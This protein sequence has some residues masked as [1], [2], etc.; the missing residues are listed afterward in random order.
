MKSYFHLA[1]AAVC[2]L[3]LAGGTVQHRICRT[4]IKIGDDAAVGYVAPLL[5]GWGND[6][7][8]ACIIQQIYMMFSV[9]MSASG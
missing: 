2:I 7:I 1:G 6:L 3:M 4:N 5:S 8:P 9:S